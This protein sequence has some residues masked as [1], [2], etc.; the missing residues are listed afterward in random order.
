MMSKCDYVASQ[1]IVIR[2]C[3]TAPKPKKLII[4]RH[5]GVHTLLIFISHAIFFLFLTV[6]FSRNMIIIYYFIIIIHLFNTLMLLE[7]IMH[8]IMFIIFM[9]IIINHV[10]LLLFI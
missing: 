1:N 9:V 10:S 6:S 3:M 8:Q 2:L 4:V 7:L 5:K